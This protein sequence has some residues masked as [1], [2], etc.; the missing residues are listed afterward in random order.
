MAVWEWFGW[1]RWARLA[2]YLVGLNVV[3]QA[4]YAVTGAAGL[5]LPLQLLTTVVI[6]VAFV[7]KVLPWATTPRVS[8]A[9]AWRPPRL[10]VGD[11]LVEA[12]LVRPGGRVE[13]VTVVVHQDGRTEG[14]SGPLD[15]GPDDY[16]ITM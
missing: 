5:P 4:S 11:N 1:V 9:D 7:K 16:L 3:I 2:F 12:R 15:V 6:G 13:F 10:R 8:D 14:V